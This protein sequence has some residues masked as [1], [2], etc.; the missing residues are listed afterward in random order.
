VNFSTSCSVAFAILVSA[1]FGAADAQPRP[2]FSHPLTLRHEA[3]DRMR[4]LNGAQAFPETLR[5]LAAMAAFQED[6]DSRSSGTGSFDTSSTTKR[7]L[8]PPPHD[9]A[10]VQQHLTFLENYFRRVSHGKLIVKADVLDPVYRLPFQM[11]HYSPPRGSTDNAELGLLMQDAWHLVDSTTPGIPFRN[12][13]AFLILHAGSGRDVDLTS[14][15]GFDPTP[16]DVPSIYLNLA[17]L[18]RMFGDS[19]QGVSVDSGRFTIENSMIL[20][21]TESRDVSTTLGTTR[22]Q[23]GINGLLCAS[24]GSHLGLP[25]L[26]DTKTGA[27]GIGRFGLMDGQSIF[28]WNGLFP[29]EPSAWERYFLRWINPITLPPGDLTYTLPAAGLSNQE[30]SVYRVL[31]SAREY[32][33]LEN[34]NRDANRDGSTVTFVRNGQT[35][36]RTWSRD[37]TGFNA[38][39]VDSLYGVV[40]DVDEPD[41][42]LPGGVSSTT[43]E[44]FD[45]GILIWHIDENVIETNYEADAVNADPNRRGVNLEEA[46]GSQ[47]IGQ[48][49][50][51]IS[52][53]SGSENGTV[54]DFW[55]SG[56]RAPLRIQS[57]AFTPDS[58]PGSESNDHA[59]S[60]FSV[61][62]FSPRGPRMTARFQT[63]DEQIS[64]LPGFPKE[65]SLGFGRNSITVGSS[66]AG[67]PSTLLVATLNHGPAPVPSSGVPPSGEAVGT[68][69][70]FG[71]NVDGTPIL[72]AGLPSGQLTSAGGTYG[73]FKG[74]IAAGEFNGDGTPDLAIAGSITGS[75]PLPPVPSETRDA[76]NWTLRDSDGDHLIDT[77]FISHLGRSITTSPVVSDSFV[78]YGTTG[79][80]V[81]LLR[82]NG[83]VA[84]SIRV[85]PADSS[86]VVSLSLAQNPASF[87]AVTSNGSIG[88]AGLICADNAATSGLAAIRPSFA[89]ASTL[90]ASSGKQLIL[91]SKDGLVS[92]RGVCTLIARGGFTIPTGG[93]IL[94]A[95]AVADIDGDGSKDIIVCSA[96]R[97]YAINAVG[98]ILDNF[99]VTV[100]SAKTILTSPIVADI[101]GDGSVDIVV[102]TQEGL[103]VAY[104]KTGRMVRGFPLLAGANAGSTPAA[105]YMPSACLS[106]TDIGL[107]VASDDGH[108]Y[109]WKTGTLRT[110]LLPA[111]V[112]PWPQY[113]HDERNSGLSDSVSTPPPPLSD[114]FPASR[115]YNWPN[116]VDRDHGYKT[117]IRYYVNS[118]AQVHIKIFDLAGDQVTEFDAPGAGG[119]DNE[120]EWDVSSIQSGIYFAHLEAQGTGGSGT[121]VIKIAVV[122]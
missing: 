35:V 8:D 50:G 120:V 38:F 83:S 116:P 100:P 76:F 58:H 119:L 12:Y 113:M 13:G 15:F 88:G 44:F 98:S 114:F 42:S 56:N 121:A 22:L 96:N 91:V 3:G 11:R 43:H 29:P 109:G 90:S 89:I 80:M 6:A 99:P 81:Y 74:K 95:P 55:Y 39:D 73:I 2:G 37:A 84:E 79:G 30:D 47:D 5:V 17:A 70:V 10:Y 48:T 9:R 41:W 104:D 102:V 122:K 20:P 117:H 54:L 72:P 92:A 60:H 69:Q 1:A 52:S 49:Y 78:A 64:L 110:G 108:V 62:E 86:D 111:P 66:P 65:T 87:L 59:N 63:G 105:F 31:I 106:C 82:Y 40:T 19:Y 34:R 32:F 61:R 46:D 25:D 33:L 28:S 53:G 51:L 68:S 7:W 101:D 16:F 23:L 75:F 94:N 115:A 18:K 21:E 14:L 97:I 112:Q 36:T 85:N 26:F 107:A 57:N 77:L 24:V 118:T 4:A 71:W 27:T 93:E 45:G 67:V 103:V